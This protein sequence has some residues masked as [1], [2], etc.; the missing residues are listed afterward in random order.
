M[1]TAYCKNILTFH[2]GHRKTGSMTKSSILISSIILTLIICSAPSAIAQ[3]IYL[4]EQDWIHGSTDCDKNSDPA[5]QV[6]QYNANTWILRQ[7]KCT[8]YEAP[9]MFLFLGQEKA[10]L[11]DT[12]A[13]KE[14][15]TFP[16]YTTVKEIIQRYEKA[17]NLN[18]ELIVAHTHA[19]GDHRAADGQ[20]EGKLKTSVV[21]L[22]VKAV[23]EFFGI[24]NWP[25]D[26]VLLDLGNRVL[27]IIPIPGH[28]VSSI[29]VYDRSTGLLLTGDTLYPGRL[30]VKEWAE[31][32]RS[33]KRLLDFTKKNRITYILGN[34]IEM[35]N[36]AGV[37]Y[38][39]NTLY[40]P[41]EQILPLTVADLEV[42]NNALL[43]VGDVPTRVV[44]DK[45]IIY[46][47]N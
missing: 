25:G 18:L 43:E 22:N 39:M 44:R 34:H 2:S 3:S 9:F 37:D 7:S 42:L 24:A 23:Q 33:I 38:P 20:F 6:V 29:A 12:G 46:P 32:K 45:F 41:E 30:Y 16:L 17:Q 4:A 28:Q 13:T 19:H 21:G 10:L 36:V 40:Q 15:A 14:E 11:M 26:Q 47:I 27:D 31:F 35:T 8:N 5:I 1:K